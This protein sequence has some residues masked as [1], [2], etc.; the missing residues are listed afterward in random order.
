M[1][2]FA[3]SSGAHGRLFNHTSFNQQEMLSFL[4]DWRLPMIIEK[5]KMNMVTFQEGMSSTF[6]K[7]SSSNMHRRL[8]FL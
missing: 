4:T 1:K 8:E 5:F 7:P 3:K 2:H 6:M